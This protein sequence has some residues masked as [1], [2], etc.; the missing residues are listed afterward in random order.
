LRDR[1]SATSDIAALFSSRKRPGRLFTANNAA[2]LWVI[3]ALRNLNIEA[4]R[5]VSLIGF[6][7]VDFFTL[8]TPPVI[9][10]RQ[11]AD[12][13]GRLAT[14]RLLQKIRGDA[15]TS[16][17]RTVLPVSLIVRESCGCQRRE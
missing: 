3:E 16:G 6:D 5:D 17:A 9:T 11:P 10:V 2:T 14:P 7:D 15:L 13:L 1:A 8:I 12:E 4:G